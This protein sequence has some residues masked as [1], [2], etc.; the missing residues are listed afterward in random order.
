M[1]LSNYDK[2]VNLNCSNNLITQLVDLPHTLTHLD[3]SNNLIIILDK[4]PVNMIKFNW[5]SNPIKCIGI[6]NNNFFDKFQPNLSEL[7]IG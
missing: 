1:D 5:D 2:L 7:L 4:I 6:P 3:C